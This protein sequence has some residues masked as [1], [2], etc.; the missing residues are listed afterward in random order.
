[1]RSRNGLPALGAMMVVEDR[2]G[3]VWVIVGA[4]VRTAM[5]GASTPAFGG[6]GG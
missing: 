3:A 4:D 1:M 5:T 2:R 6:A